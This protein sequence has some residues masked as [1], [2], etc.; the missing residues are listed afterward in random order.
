MLVEYDIL[1]NMGKEYKSKPKLRDDNTV[2]ISQAKEKMY[3]LKE[4]VGAFWAGRTTGIEKARGI[5]SSL[6]GSEDTDEAVEWIKEN[7]GL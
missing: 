6:K 4:V 1:T 7:L 5:D 3:N 2:I